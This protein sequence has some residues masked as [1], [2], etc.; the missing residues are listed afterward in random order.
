VPA[1]ELKNVDGI[2]YREALP[3]APAGAS[4]VLCIH[5]FPQSSYMWRQLLEALAASGRRALAP[6][7]LGFG[8]T[9][10]DPPGTWVRQVEHVERFRTALG[11]ERVE[12]VVHDWG[13]L[14][15][16]RWACDHPYAVSSLV[17]SN[18]GFFP[19]GK[20]NAM[21]VTLRTEGQGEMLLDNLN[22]DAFA[23]M[24]RDLS[25]SFDNAA[26]D[27]Y[28][29]A[30]ESEAGRRG[31]LELYR[32]GDFDELRPY[33][34]R[35][36]QLGA[37]ALILWGE[38]DAFAPVAAAHRFHRELPDSQLVTLDAGHFVYEDQP[39]RCAQEIVDFL[40]RSR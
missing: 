8:D 22:R 21:A 29:K 1:A 26:I 23:A 17:L 9:S 27:E 31:A 39:E 30:F 38:N 18:T 14:I 16:L 37:P 10:P 20:W 25:R 32:S 5:G 33:Q 13:G 12:L 35:L 3:E 36:E 19:D 2:A 11:L 7:L 6:D 15:G 34:E 4:T 40:D 24:M 28:F